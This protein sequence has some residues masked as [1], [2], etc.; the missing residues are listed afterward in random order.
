MAENK[1]LKYMI[2]KAAEKYKDKVLYRSEKKS[3]TYK[4]FQKQINELGTA[5][6]YLGLKNKK[7]A[8]LSENRYEWEI[9]FLAIATGNKIVVP[10]DKSLTKKEIENILQRTEAEAI[11][12]SEKYQKILEEIKTNCKC[13]KYIISFDG[14]DKNSFISLI[15]TG[16]ALIEENYNKFI[17]EKIDDDSICSIIFTSG[18]TNK[19]KAVML[20]HKNIYSNIC[21][22]SEVL[23]LDKNDIALSILPLNHVLEG[24]F[25]F[26]V[27]IQK[28]MERIFCDDISEILEYI[29]K[30]K[31]T[32]M[33]GVPSIYEY[34]Y[35]SK[36]KLVQEADHIKMF[37]SGGAKLDP[38]IVS[39]YKDLGITIIQGYG[40][41]ECA[42]VI[43]IENKENT[44]IGSVGKPIPNVEVMVKNKDENGI[45]ELIVRG[46][47][48]TKGYFQDEE[49]TNK[50][51]KDG[52]LYTGDLGK[53]DDDG[54]IY[55][56]GRNKDLIVLQNGKKIFPEEIE[57]LLNKI[58]G[59]KESVVFENSANIHDVKIYAK[60]VYNPNEF[61]EKQEEKIKEI[62]LEKVKNINEMLPNYKKINDI[63]ITKE[64][65][66]KT[67]TGKIQREKEKK[68][69]TEKLDNHEEKLPTNNF[70]II[71]KI[72][73]EIVGEKDIT[74]NSKLINDLG[75][76]SLDI[77]GIY[78]KIEKKFGINIP[79]EK[80][81]KIV[82]VQDLLD[83]IK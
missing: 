66:E 17:E 82:T 23:E 42:P 25:C 81:S 40:M 80:R 76:D 16:K 64:M 39:N 34:L 44:R 49:E 27:S 8:I 31:I 79:N 72:I 36:E 73:R 43:S 20:T 54:Y 57:N 53:I 50:L 60:I 55:I 22:V 56:Y 14:N 5:I 58:D 38:Q 41:T 9:A 37:M 75:A 67:S 68:M 61:E 65:L 52:W 6:T 10:I 47:N 70:E 62:L 46:E 71:C 45:G 13:L 63:F 51:I 24:L 83:A 7:I 18:T 21:N 3:I 26:L 1:N 35:Q 15:E 48:I 32:Y 30:Y 11:F 59:V 29:K 74:E 4:E 77:V 69:N 28:G 33:G 78:L 19:S 2:Q 12:C